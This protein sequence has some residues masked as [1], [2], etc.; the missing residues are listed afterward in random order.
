MKRSLVLAAAAAATLLTA[1]AANA[2]GVNWSI[3]INV[4]PVAT[5]VSSGPAYYTPSSSYYYSAP[6]YGYDVQPSY[7]AP[8]VYTAPRY[9]EPEVVY[10]PRPR[11]WVAPRP[12]WYG[13]HDR[14]HHEGRWDRDHGRDRD[15]DH[16]RWRHEG[17]VDWRR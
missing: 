7:Y 4:P 9:Y 2:H 12:V 6:S 15:G 1:T 8:P 17:R 13:G 14:W 11:Y 10:A 16:D 3:G 5:V